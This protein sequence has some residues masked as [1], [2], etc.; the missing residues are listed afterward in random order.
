MEIIL[1]S[2]LL[3]KIFNSETKLEIKRFFSL[4]YK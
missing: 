1:F 4:K 3:Q 2:G